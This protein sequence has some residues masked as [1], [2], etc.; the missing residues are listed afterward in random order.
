MI[1]WLFVHHLK[2]VRS[3]KPAPLTNPMSPAFALKHKLF[4]PIDI[5]DDDKVLSVFVWLTAMLLSVAL[6]SGQV[7]G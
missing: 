4:I 6:C 5:P 7:M 3:V 2:G 1:S